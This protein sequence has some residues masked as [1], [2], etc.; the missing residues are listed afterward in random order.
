M[1]LFTLATLA[2]LAWSESVKYA[3]VQRRR[4]LRAQVDAEI[5]QY[6]DDLI[7]SVAIALKASWAKFEIPSMVPE[8]VMSRM[9]SPGEKAVDLSPLFG[10]ACWC[11]FGNVNSQYGRGPP[12]DGTDAVCQKLVLCYRCIIVDAENSNEDCDPYTQTFDATVIVS[13]IG[14]GLNNITT[15]CMSNNNNNCAWMTCSCTMTLTDNLINLAFDPNDN[16]N[17]DYKHENGFDYALDCPQQG[18]SQ[19][20][21]CCGHYPTRRTYDRHAER[22]C[23]HEKSIYNPLRHQCCEDGS[24]IGL[25]N[26]CP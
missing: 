7:P 24:H 20:R 16:Y 18:K 14:G 9:D 11:F 3:S 25:G 1:K 21:Q 2:G 6:Q 22:A 17:N 15:G 8:S 13:G 5:D 4:S 19:D 12:L 10:Y 23:C 26:R